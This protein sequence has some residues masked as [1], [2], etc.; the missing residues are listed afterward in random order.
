MKNDHFSVIRIS[1][2][3]M[4][5]NFWVLGSQGIHKGLYLHFVEIY[6]LLIPIIRILEFLL[7]TE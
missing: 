5:S 1:N 7:I 3:D 4:L 2:I 6:Q